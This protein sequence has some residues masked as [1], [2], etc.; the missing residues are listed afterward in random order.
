MDKKKN[1]LT[2]CSTCPT[3]FKNINEFF[4]DQHLYDICMDL[5]KKFKNKIPFKEIELYPNG[6][7]RPLIEYQSIN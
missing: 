1:K 5:H 7:W 2:K 6:Q 3:K 4:L